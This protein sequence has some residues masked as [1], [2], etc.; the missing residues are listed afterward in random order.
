MAVELFPQL[1]FS[2]CDAAPTIFTNVMNVIDVAKVAVWNCL[3]VIMHHSKVFSLL[4]TLS[5]I[6]GILL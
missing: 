3:V 6:Q 4:D 1:H 5:I 2:E